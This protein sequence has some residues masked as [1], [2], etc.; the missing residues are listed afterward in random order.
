MSSPDRDLLLPA[1]PHRR[2]VLSA[3]ALGLLAGGCFTPMYAERS[4]GVGI[5]S[6]MENVEVKLIPNRVGLEV[7]NA[8]IFELSGGAGNP[9][10]A[11]YRIDIGLVE[12]VQSI[13]INVR[14]GRATTELVTLTATYELR[15]MT[16]KERVVMRDT[17]NSQASIERGA[18]VFAR[19]RAIRDAENRAA[20][21]VAEQI[22]LR[23]ASFFA[24]NS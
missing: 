10:N 22:K 4:P 3:L 9:V 7:R 20:R 14:T 18:Q 8:L 19:D 24:A 6:S 15:D 13:T 2:A 16:K 21:M 17:S 12:D 23:L 1:R 5:R 11:P